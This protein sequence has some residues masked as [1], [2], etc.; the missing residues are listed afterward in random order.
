MDVAEDHR[1]GPLTATE[2]RLV[3]AWAEVLGI[4]KHQIGR[5][6]DFFDLG[7][8]SLSAVKLAITLNRAVSIKDI[9]RHT[10]LADLAA[11]IDSRAGQPG[12]TNGS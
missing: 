4:A 10:V 11:L 3:A 5:R 9:A 12:G 6:D 1:G 8:T 2:Q 7:G